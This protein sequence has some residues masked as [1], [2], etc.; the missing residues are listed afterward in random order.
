MMTLL[1]YNFMYLNG[2]VCKYLENCRYTYLYIV[3]IKLLPVLQ[4]FKFSYVIVIHF[5][6]HKDGI[7]SRK[8]FNY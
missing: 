3:S 5:L 6:A 4:T 7:C 1:R 2:K 8:V